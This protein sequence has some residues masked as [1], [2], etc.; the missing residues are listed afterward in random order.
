[1]QRAS[2]AL[3][4]VDVLGNVF[5]ADRGLP[6]GFEVPGEL[7]WAPGLGQFDLDHYPG[8]GGNTGAVLTGPH[9]GL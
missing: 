7:L 8:F 2:C 6:I 1:M 3:V 5:V 9:A 4:G